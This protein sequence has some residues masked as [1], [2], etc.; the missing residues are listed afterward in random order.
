MYF[1]FY[2]CFFFFF[3][4]FVCVCVCF[5][6]CVCVFFFVCVCVCGFFCFFFFFEKA[7]KKNQY[8]D[9]KRYDLEVYILHMP[10]Y[11]TVCC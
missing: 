8:F 9:L 7:E 5:C 10:V 6:V 2:C 3:F 11:V 1:V 4:F